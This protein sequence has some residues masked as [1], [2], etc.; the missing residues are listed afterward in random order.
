MNAFCV[1]KHFLYALRDHGLDLAFSETR[2]GFR[3]LDVGIFWDVLG[4]TMDL[5]NFRPPVS[6]FE[7]YN[8]YCQ[9]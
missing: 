8:R 5:S 2:K 3:S 9:I 6:A 4:S 7:A 1:S